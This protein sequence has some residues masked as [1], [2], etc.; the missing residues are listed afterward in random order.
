MLL[1]SVRI[2]SFRA[3]FVKNNDGSTTYYNIMNPTDSSSILN[4]LYHET[5]HNFYE[6]HTENKE[7]INQYGQYANA[8]GHHEYDFGTE[9]NETIARVVTAIM[10]INT[11]ESRLQMTILIG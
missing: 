6:V 4:T 7:L 3:T 2:K 5:A 11:M 8:L 1:Q 10:L 9:V